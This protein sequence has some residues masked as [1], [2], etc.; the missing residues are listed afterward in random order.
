MRIPAIRCIDPLTNTVAQTFPFDAGS[1]SVMNEH[2]LISY[3]NF[4]SGSSSIGLFN[5]LT[6]QLT[7]P[8]YISTAGITTLYGVQYSPATNKIY[9]SDANS[10]TNTGSILLFSAAGVFERSYSVG[11]NPSKILIYE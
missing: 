2:L 7:D 10:F 6:E 9:C 5:A 1:M 3:Y 4:S 8:N 11:L